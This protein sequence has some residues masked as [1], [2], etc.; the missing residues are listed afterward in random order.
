MESVRVGRIQQW[1]RLLMLCALVEANG[2]APDS[3]A[4]S[5]TATLEPDTIAV[6]DTAALKLVFEGSGQIQLSPV[7]RIPGLIISGPEQGSST[8]IVNGQRTDTVSATYYLRPTQTNV[9]TIPPLTARISDEEFRSPPLRL[10]AVKATRSS[11]DQ[12]LA[13]L[14]LVVPRERLYVGE[15]VIIELQL[16]LNRSVS[17][18]SDFDMPDFSGSGWL[19]GQPMQGQKRQVQSAGQIMTMVP[20]QIPLTPLAVGT[21]TLGPVKSTVVVQVPSQ[22]RSNDL[23]GMGFF[24]RTEPRRVTLA[25]PRHDLEV[26]PLPDT[27]VPDTFAGAVGQFEMV[28]AAGPTNVT[29]G[30]PITLR[31]QLS[32]TGNMNSV[33][34]RESLVSGDFKTYEPETK[35][36][37]TDRFGFAGIKTVEQIVIP[38]NTEVR[39]LPPIVFS[40]FDPEAGAYRTLTHPATPLSVMPAGPRPAP[41]VAAANSQT[42]PDLPRQDIVHIKQRLGSVHS[43]PG[44][45]V[46]SARF[47]AFNSLPMLAWVSVIAWRKRQE[48]IGRNP[49]LRREQ[50][51]RR[52]IAAGLK[53]LEQLS[54]DGRSDE[55]FSTV[56]RLLQE[57]IGF[58]LNQPASGITESVVDEKLAHLNTSEETLA[59]LHELFQACNVVRYAPTQDRQ[60]LT[61]LLPR[62]RQAL[63]ELQE[64][65]P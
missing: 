1:I 6:G 32:G 59:T 26:L 7:P 60:E 16:L 64:V 18:I 27:D 54:K 55:F 49:R 24:Q 8:R 12:S 22:R 13:S 57:Q 4:A 43:K 48:I 10:K 58:R 47:M 21:L 11:D 42:S 52:Y 62:L 23:F 53:Q 34:L 15:N 9:F 17:N 20:I 19:A 3:S 45:S 28:V 51:V 65:K 31:V 63:S 37:T 50:E 39:I 35:L 25:L 2:V 5:F 36:D 56:F 46:L 33:S 44:T 61:A 29:V 40:Y 14:R 30:D 41:V 38:E